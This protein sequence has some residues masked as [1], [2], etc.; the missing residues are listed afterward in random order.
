MT[1]ITGGSR[2]RTDGLDY[3][4]TSNLGVPVLRQQ[5]RLSGLPIV[6]NGP[7]NGKVS[8]VIEIT[9]YRA[10][11]EPWGVF[12]NLYRCTIRFD[13]RVFPSSEHAYQFGKARKIEVAEWLMAAPSGALL[14]MA[15][16][17]LFY[18]D[19]APGWSKTKV[20]RMRAVLRAKF[21]QHNYLQK[22]LLSTGDAT[23]VETPTVADQAALFWGRADGKGKNTLGVLLMELR[24]KL[25]DEQRRGGRR[26]P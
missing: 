20:D 15:A 14:A 9:F 19:I 12:S 22:T 17:G 2:W 26:T 8:S 23:L 16:H 10:S 25:R 24:R 11:K 6:R 5:G 13:G 7:S 1:P 21:T 4:V 3:R 18:W